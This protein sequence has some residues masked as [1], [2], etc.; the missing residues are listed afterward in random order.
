MCLTP[1]QSVLLLS[2]SIRTLFEG[3]LGQ[4]TLLKLVACEASTGWTQPKRKP[5]KL[6]KPLGNR[7]SKNSKAAGNL[8][9]LQGLRF[10]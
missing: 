2:V 10:W 8:H 5:E 6:G 1:F 7:P 3:E 4:Q 9:K